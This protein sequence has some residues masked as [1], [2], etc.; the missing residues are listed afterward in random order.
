MKKIQNKQETFPKGFYW[1]E[2]VIYETRKFYRGKTF[3]NFA[4]YPETSKGVMPHNI[5]LDKQQAIK[6]FL[7]QE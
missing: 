6:W 7:S 1:P 3:P 2:Y 5:V 4:F